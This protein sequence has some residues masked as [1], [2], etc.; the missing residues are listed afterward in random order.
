MIVVC[1]S[2]AIGLKKN[3]Y[4][5]ELIHWAGW[6]FTKKIFMFFS[7]SLFGNDRCQAINGK[8]GQAFLWY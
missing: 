4:L 8:T 3:K 7:L 5:W 1:L 6:N 2:K